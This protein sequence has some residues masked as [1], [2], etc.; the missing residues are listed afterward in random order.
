MILLLSNT[1]RNVPIPKKMLKTIAT[2]YH[3]QL[4]L[5]LLIVVSPSIKLMIN[6]VLDNFIKND[7]PADVFNQA[8]STSFFPDKLSLVY[9]PKNAFSMFL[10]E[11]AVRLRMS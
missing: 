10:F 9:A 6:I 7:L 5:E 4:L 11:Y 8:V 2:P 3:I 1:A